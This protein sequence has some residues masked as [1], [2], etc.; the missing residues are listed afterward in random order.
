MDKIEN[1]SFHVALHGNTSEDEQEVECEACD[2]HGNVTCG[3]CDG[4]GEVKC[5]ACD[6]EG[7][8]TEDGATIVECDECKAEC[9]VGCETCREYGDVDCAA[10]GATGSITLAT[11]LHPADAYTL[12]ALRQI[13]PYGAQES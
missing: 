12:A 13:R 3:D 1:R 5:E 9:W 11:R 2:G 8:Y 4:H 6:G 10:C 7:H